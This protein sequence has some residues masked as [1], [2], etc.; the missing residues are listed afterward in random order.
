MAIFLIYFLSIFG[1]F[2][3]GISIGLKISY[4][5]DI[6]KK[7]NKI[8]ILT[9]AKNLENLAKIFIFMTIILFVFGRI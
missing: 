6:A 5:K 3:A 9:E 1:I 2:A 8:E 4:D 7:Y